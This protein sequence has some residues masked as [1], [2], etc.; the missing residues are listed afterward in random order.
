VEG[1]F[2]NPPPGTITAVRFDAGN[3]RHRVTG[4]AGTD[5][6]PEGI[7]VSPDGRFVVTSNLTSSWMP[8]NDKR[9]SPG[10]SMNLLQLHPR[11][12]RLT[13]VQH[14]PLSGI[15]PDGVTF[16]A[17]GDHVAVSNFDHYDPRHRRSTVQFFSLD[18]GACPSL[19]RT[20]VELEVPAGAHALW[21]I[22]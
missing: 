9:M 1:L 7:A 21:L 13:T 2:Y 11:S 6:S 15:L 10:G 14:V 16:D 20:N 8:W 3:G 12:G 17:S 19:A 4:R 18:R 22:R 5:V